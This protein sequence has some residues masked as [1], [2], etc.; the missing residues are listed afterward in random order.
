MVELIDLLVRCEKFGRDFMMSK[1]VEKES[2]LDGD[3]YIIG[4]IIENQEN[5]V[6]G[7]CYF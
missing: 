1:W 5:V 4:V 2:V 6:L 3:I 7:I